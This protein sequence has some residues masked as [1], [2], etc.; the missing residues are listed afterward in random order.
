VVRSALVARAQG[1]LGAQRKPHMAGG[2]IFYGA[3][4]GKGGS[5]H[6]CGGLFDQVGPEVERPCGAI[7]VG[8][9]RRM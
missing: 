7:R 9:R 4:T 3:H 8:C 2:S 5:P 6:V 1:E